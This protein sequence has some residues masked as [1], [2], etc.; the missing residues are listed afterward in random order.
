MLYINLTIF[1][2]KMFWRGNNITNDV[3]YCGA[4]IF[5]KDVKFSKDSHG[6]KMSWRFCI[7]GPILKIQDLHQFFVIGEDVMNILYLQWVEVTPQLCKF[8]G[9]CFFSLYIN[10]DSTLL[11]PSVR[12]TWVSA[13]QYFCLRKLLD[14]RDSA[15]HPPLPL[16]TLPPYPSTLQLPCNSLDTHIPICLEIPGLRQKAGAAHE[17]K[18]LSIPPV[19]SGNLWDLV[20]TPGSLGLTR[21]SIYELTAFWFVY[22]TA[23]NPAHH[24][25]LYTC[26]KNSF[27]IIN[28]NAI[29]PTS[30]YFRSIRHVYNP[31]THPR[32]LSQS[33][34]TFLQPQSICQPFCWAKYRPKCCTAY[35][36]PPAHWCDYNG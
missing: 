2:A 8:P 9:V 4:W 15:I 32:P 10:F 28:L 35:W 7:F 33:I 11:S 36:K 17:L 34:S 1:K 29:I 31:S 12:T 18:P 19:T 27:C 22:A 13:L 30:I 23:G 3:I 25:Q 5:F 6:S 14:P 26:R 20:F 24:L 21:N 16:E